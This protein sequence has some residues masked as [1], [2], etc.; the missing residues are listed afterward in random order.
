MEA[1][2]GRAGVMDG[3]QRVPSPATLRWGAV[4]GGCMG[5]RRGSETMT[6]SRGRQEQEQVSR[7]LYVGSR[8]SSSPFCAAM[9][10]TGKL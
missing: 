4:S 7:V 2:R 3:H 8:S 9:G 5:G 10:C 1:E 6:R